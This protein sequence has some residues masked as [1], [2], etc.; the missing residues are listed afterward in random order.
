[1][2][3]GSFFLF[4]FGCVA[5]TAL[6]VGASYAVARLRAELA[7]RRS[8]EGHR[9]DLLTMKD[10]LAT[11]A[12][13]LGLRFGDT[14]YE[15]LWDGRPVS[16]RLEGADGARVLVLEVRGLADSFWVSP[17]PHDAATEVPTGDADFD[18]RFQVQGDGRQA[19]AALSHRARGLA[20]GLLGRLDFRVCLGGLTAE[21]PFDDA[22]PHRVAATLASALALVEAMGG[23]AAIDER[24]LLAVAADPCPATRAACLKVLMTSPETEPWARSRAGVM[25]ADA[26][27]ARTRL[28]GAL[29]APDDRWSVLVSIAGDAAVDPGLRSRALEALP[30]GLTRESLSPVRRRELARRVLRDVDVELRLVGA[31]WVARGG[32]SLDAAAERAL[33]ELLEIAEGPERLE[34]FDALARAGTVASVEAL[35]PHTRRVLADALY[36]QSARDAVDAIQARAGGEA[37]ALTL[38]GAEGQSGELS[39]A[40]SGAGAVSIAGPSPG[41]RS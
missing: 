7:L 14:G 17:V 11:I 23:A 33:V 8:V 37:G 19:L 1:M 20:R 12:E 34:V 10:E 39:L 13:G 24:L 16:L 2:S 4:A 9:A 18:R 35:L 28:A 25:T 36:R 27:D 3:S 15:G 22:D 6:C 5:I 38:T 41:E 31:R 32:A 30:E 26:D 40:R 21:V 29:M